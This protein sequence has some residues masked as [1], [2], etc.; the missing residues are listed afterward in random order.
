M[1]IGFLALLM[2]LAVAGC[3]KSFGEVYRDHAKQFVTDI[4]LK[5]WIDSGVEFLLVDLR[6]PTLYQQGHIET[7]VNVPY[8]QLDRLR[9]YAN[10][11]TPVVIYSN[12]A[13]IQKSVANDLTKRGYKNVRQLANGVHAWRYEFVK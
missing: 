10:H 2:M 9:N 12:E 3:T 7:A 1:K 6:F 5:G 11:N 4:E 8:N 13:S